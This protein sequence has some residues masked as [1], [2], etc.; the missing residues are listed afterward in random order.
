[1]NAYAPYMEALPMPLTDVDQSTF[2]W[3]KFSHIEFLMH[4]KVAM[5][6]LIEQGAL[7]RLMAYA[8]RQVPFASLPDEP[9]LLA[10]MV[11][12]PLPRWAKMA[13]QVLGAGFELCRD[14]RYYC[15][16]MTDELSA[17][18]AKPH[19]STDDQPSK[20]AE[21]ARRYR[22]NKKQR[23]AHRD[24]ST[25][26]TPKTVTHRDANVTHR[27]E[28]VTR[29][30]A[31]VTIGGIKGGDL[32]LDLDL[33]KPT[34]LPPLPEFKEQV[35]RAEKTFEQSGIKIIPD[36]WVTI[37]KSK[38]P[39]ISKNQIDLIFAKMQTVYTSQT[40]F[41][42]TKVRDWSTKWNEFVVRHAP[43]IIAQSNQFASNQPQVTQEPEFVK[44]K[45]PVKHGP[46]P[47][48]LAEQ[49]KQAAEYL[50]SRTGGAA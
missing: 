7:I 23:D 24:E 8:A 1:M 41:M 3:F 13:D 32:D 42:G 25:T 22:E 27:D 15:P 28:S 38:Y 12:L 21:R 14:G 44:P 33:N 9:E 35:D 50:A 47:E 48:Q 29:H 18:V 43:S 46:S 6:K 34:P 16:L 37:A 39:D 11:G 5:L 30:D 45:A 17:P 20:D 4:P 31:T 26:V 19:E 10:A 40:R 49:R 2:A 36:H